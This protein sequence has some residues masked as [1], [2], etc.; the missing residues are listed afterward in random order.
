MSASRISLLLSFAIQLNVLTDAMPLVFVFKGYK[1]FFYSNEGDPREP[2]HVHVRKGTN[3]AK[4][5]VKPS[6]Q[7]SDSYGFSGKELN[8][9]SEII[10]NRR[11][12]IEESWNEHFK[13]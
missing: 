4:F 1:F 2:L 11:L 9:L 13:P 3:L 10:Y 6:I 12:E 5:W 8:W 7:L